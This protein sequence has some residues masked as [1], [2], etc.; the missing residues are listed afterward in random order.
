MA[1]AKRI[2]LVDMDGVVADFEGGFV[3]K[4][5]AKHPDKP[6]VPLE[7]RTTFYSFKQYPLLHRP[8]VWN[9]MMAPDFF[10]DLPPIEGSIKAVKRMARSGLEIFFCSSPLI[11]N[12]TG[13]SEKYAWI[14][15]HFGITWVDKL[16]LAP[17]KTLVRGDIL[18]DDR[19]EI[20][21]SQTPSWEHVLY[22]QPYNREIK[23]RRRLTWA[24][25]REVIL[26]KK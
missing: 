6:F 3:E 7:D 19:P 14:K 25:W 1:K 22:D 5:K 18:I 10:A 23:D 20:K 2:I 17:D 24:N 8:L 16:I 26:K 9:I 15:K 11:P 4:W 13:A 12:R 21:G